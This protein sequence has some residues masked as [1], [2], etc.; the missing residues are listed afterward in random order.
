MTHIK[1][2]TIKMKVETYDYHFL[3]ILFIFLIFLKSVSFL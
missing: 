1:E 2:T 3:N